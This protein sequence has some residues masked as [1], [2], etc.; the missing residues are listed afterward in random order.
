M[1]VKKQNPSLFKFFSS[2]DEILEEVLDENDLDTFFTTLFL[3]F[4]GPSIENYVLAKV[5]TRN[6]LHSS[7]SILQFK[8]QLQCFLQ[9]E[10]NRS[11]REHS[12]LVN[13]QRVFLKTF[14]KASKSLQLPILNRIFKIG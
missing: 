14:D 10:I 6:H 12:C 9:G 3:T 13:R 2:Y 11:I 5:P 8:A 1:S 4:P 7:C